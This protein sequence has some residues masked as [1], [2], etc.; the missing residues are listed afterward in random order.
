LETAYTARLRPRLSG[1]LSGAY[2][3]RTDT[4]TF[5]HPG[6][7]PLS[8]SPFMGGEIYG[9]LSWVPSSDVLVSAGGGVFVPQTGKVFTG[10]ADL[11]YRFS[12][13]ASILF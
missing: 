3:F 1:D 11:I 4:V 8:N 13:A 10:D 6:I 5:Y 12:L 9:G 7:D 2:Y